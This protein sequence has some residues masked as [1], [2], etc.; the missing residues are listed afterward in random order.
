VPDPR[1]QEIFRGPITHNVAV[2]SARYASQPIHRA[3]ALAFLH[4]PINALASVSDLRKRDVCMP[5]EAWAFRSNSR[6]VM[7]S[8]LLMKAGIDSG[9]NFYNG[10]KFTVGHDAT[11]DMWQTRAVLT[12]DAHPIKPENHRLLRNVQPRGYGY[13]HDCSTIAGPEDYAKPVNARGSVWYAMVP[14]GAHVRARFPISA[15]NR[16]PAQISGP[17]GDVLEIDQR[18]QHFP[19]AAYYGY[20]IYR[21]IFSDGQNIVDFSAAPVLDKLTFIK[22]NSGHNH[23]CFDGYNIRFN[24][25]TGTYTREEMGTGHRGGRKFN[26]P[27]AKDYLNGGGSLLLEPQVPISQYALY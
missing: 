16:V 15:I 21:D 14:R 5:M 7:G 6:T 9:A 22:D 12:T 24:Y 13:G 19:G 4:T 25:A 10:A 18:A 8:L 20:N 1:F 17:N 11:T 3:I 2:V 23:I 27:G 26:S